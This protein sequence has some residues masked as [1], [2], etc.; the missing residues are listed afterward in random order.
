MTMATGAPSL[1]VVALVAIVSGAVGPRLAGPQDRSG[2][3]AFA[4]M[5][6]A[7]FAEGTEDNQKSILGSIV[8]GQRVWVYPGNVLQPYTPN[9]TLTH[10]S[11]G[12]FVDDADIANLA[13]GMPEVFASSGVTWTEVRHENHLRPDGARVALLEGDCL[14]GELHYRS[15]QMA[16]P[17][18][19]GTSIVTASFPT[20]TAARWEPLIEASMNSATGVAFH[21][22]PP[23]AWVY[24]AWVLAGAIVAFLVLGLVR[25]NPGAAS[26]A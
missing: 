15:V 2:G 10:S 26:R 18:D 7:G 5:P 13:R 1:V 14:K 23:A 21:A 11:R 8:G 3:A 6:P 19:T 9:I 24:L 20:A 22:S 12:G 16:F 17:D 4:Y 25:H